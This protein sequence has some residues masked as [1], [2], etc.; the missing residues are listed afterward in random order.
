M[1]IARIRE[2]VPDCPECGEPLKLRT[3]RTTD[4]HFWGCTSFPKCRGTVPF[5][6]EEPADEDADAELPSER[7]AR[8]DRN[9]FRE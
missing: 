5:D 7:Q 3:N 9:R 6:T 4:E 1:A 8:L 2:T